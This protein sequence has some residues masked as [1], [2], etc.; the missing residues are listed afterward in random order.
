MAKGEPRSGGS[1]F[2]R[3]EQEIQARFGVR[4][5]L[6]ALGRRVIRDHVPDAHAEFFARLPL[7]LGGTIDEQEQPWASILVGRPGFV[8]SSVTPS[9]AP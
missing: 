3:G 5:K 2:H 8:T 6:E 1:P 9:T 4:D 7:L